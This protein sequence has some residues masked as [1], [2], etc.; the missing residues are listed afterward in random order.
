M[1]ES[2]L[3]EKTGDGGVSFHPMSLCQ[4]INYFSK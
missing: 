4:E 1:E 3:I 2:Q